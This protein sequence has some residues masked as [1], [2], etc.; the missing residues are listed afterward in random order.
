MYLRQ[1]ILLLLI[2]FANCAYAQVNI[3]GVTEDSITGKPI[4]FVK[5]EYPETSL[6]VF[7]DSEGKFKLDLP[8]RG[9]N[10]LIFSREGYFRK[11]ISVEINDTIDANKI[12]VKLQPFEVITDTI[13]IQDK[14]FKKTAEINTSH[15]NATYDEIRK[16]PGA[17]EDVIKFFE[18][19]PGVSFGADIENALIVRG[20][21]VLLLESAIGRRALP[22][23]VNPAHRVIVVGLLAFAAQVGAERAALFGRAFAHGVAGHA[24]AGLERFL[25]ARRVARLLLRQFGLHPGLPG[26]RRVKGEHADA[27]AV[28]QSALREYRIQKS[29][30]ETAQIYEWMALAHRGLGDDDVAG[31]DT[32][33][34]QSIYDQLGVEPAGI[35]GSAPPGGLTK[36]E[37]EIVTA[38]AR[39]ATNRQV[40]QQ[41]FISEKTVARHL[42]NIYA[43]LGVSSRTAAVAWAHQHN[44]LQ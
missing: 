36:R 28:L 25:A 42:A 27:V 4:S 38:I 19:A 23:I 37:L 16:S 8:H 31:A 39:G 32:A 24:T 20:G 41:I 22:R 15:S 10:K 2:H 34:A 12:Y 7:S 9:I 3:S 21:E 29:R 40:A 6:A 17:A 44:L 5:I 30:Y 14:Y 26:T 11:I 1:F 13:D 18:D 33:T 43:K 35:C